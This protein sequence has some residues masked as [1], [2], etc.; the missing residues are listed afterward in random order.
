MS[1]YRAD[2]CEEAVREVIFRNPSILG[3]LIA[4]AVFREREP[5]QYRE[6]SHRYG[7]PN[8]DKALRQLHIEVFLVW[9]NFSLSQQTQDLKVYCHSTG[10][11]DALE[12]LLALV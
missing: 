9:L 11:A 10:A 4:V 12:G 2:S 3:R 5:Q 8:V 6:L 1:N 7:A